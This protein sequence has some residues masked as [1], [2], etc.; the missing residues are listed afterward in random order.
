MVWDAFGSLQSDTLYWVDSGLAREKLGFLPLRT[1]FLPI[2]ELT[3]EEFKSIGQIAVIF[4]R[5]EADVE[6]IER[7]FPSRLNEPITLA[8]IASY[9]QGGNCEIF[10][11]F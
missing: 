4:F 10:T 3:R 11:I 8:I 5:T 7:R 1:P 9:D 6:Q 2:H